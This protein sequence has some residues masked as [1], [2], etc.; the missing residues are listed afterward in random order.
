MLC[1]IRFSIL[2]L[3]S[4]VFDNV[5]VCL[6]MSIQPIPSDSEFGNF[7]HIHRVNWPSDVKC[8]FLKLFQF[9]YAEYEPVES[10]PTMSKG[11]AVNFV[12]LG[13]FSHLRNI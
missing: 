9:F 11:H 13:K 4:V 6:S 10:G 7:C 1:R 2:F 5:L 8:S 12:K 3:I